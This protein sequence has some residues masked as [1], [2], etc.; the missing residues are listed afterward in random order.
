MF[1]R[2]LFSKRAYRLNEVREDD[3]GKF[4][5]KACTLARLT[6]LKLPVPDAFVIVSEARDINSDRLSIP[7]SLKKQI[8]QQIEHLESSTGRHFFTAEE[9]ESEVMTGGEG[10]ESAKFPLLLSVRQSSKH[11]STPLFPTSLNLGFNAEVAARA[12]KLSN[13]PLFVY[14]CWRRFI[15]DF[16]IHVL[17]ISSE[18]YSTIADDLCRDWGIPKVSQVSGP[19]SYRITSASTSVSHFHHQN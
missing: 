9:S 11:G 16:G 6:R 17:G 10:V 5:E 13:R 7:D 8:K 4:G 15:Q 3:P 19:L 1:N 18:R 2:G 12:L 14:D